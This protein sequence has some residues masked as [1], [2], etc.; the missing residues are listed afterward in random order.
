MSAWWEL[1]LYFSILYIMLSIILFP[2]LGSAFTL[3][4]NSW[5]LEFA[6]DL[7]ALICHRRQKSNVNVYEINQGDTQLL[8]SFYRMTLGDVNHI[9]TVNCTNHIIFSFLPKS[10]R[11]GIKIQGGILRNLVCIY[12]RRPVIK[13][14]LLD[15]INGRAFVRTHVDGRISLPSG[16]YE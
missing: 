12:I 4:W 8:I 6:R 7:E 14:H 13:G 15:W 10:I 16:D 5:Q 1:S 9:Y 11:V 3:L 2:S